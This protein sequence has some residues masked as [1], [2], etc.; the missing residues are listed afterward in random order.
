MKKDTLG[1]LLFGIF[2]LTVTFLLFLAT[3]MIAFDVPYRLLAV[4]IFAGLVDL[5]IVLGALA[6]GYGGVFI[7]DVV[8]PSFLKQ[9][10]EYIRSF[11]IGLFLFYFFVLLA[12][13]SIPAM[14]FF[15]TF[16]LLA[17][18]LAYSSREAHSRKPR[19]RK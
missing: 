18:S 4:F 6:L 19:R 17:S 15:L 7:L 11:G 2:I 10:P 5:A 9:I 1:G 12:S 14:V 3:D 8:Y 16:F 13:F